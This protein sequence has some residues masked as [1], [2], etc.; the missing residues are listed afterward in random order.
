[1]KNVEQDIPP[2]I[3]TDV[4]SLRRQNNARII[5]TPVIDLDEVIELSDDEDEFSVLME[6]EDRMREFSEAIIQNRNNANNPN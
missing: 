1:M 2:P 4:W 3:I 5:V 6:Q